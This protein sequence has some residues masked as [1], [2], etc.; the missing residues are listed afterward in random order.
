MP[1]YGRK[2]ILVIFSSLTNCDP[3]DILETFAKLKQKKIQASVISLSAEI[4][5][6]KNLCERAW[7]GGNFSLA[8]DKEHFEEILNRFLVPTAED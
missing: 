4:F 5:V 6:L 8:K 2:E 7:P 3:G 1:S